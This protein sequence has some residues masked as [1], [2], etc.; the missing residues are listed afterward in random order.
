MSEIRSRKV[1]LD[2]NDLLD[3]TSQHALSK[4]VDFLRSDTSIGTSL[5]VSFSVTELSTLLHNVRSTMEV[6]CGKESS[7]PR[8]ITKFPA[9][10]F[11]DFSEN[12]FVHTLTRI[13]LLEATKRKIS[14]VQL[15]AGEVKAQAKL[16]VSLEQQLAKVCA[17]FFASMIP[18]HL[19]EFVS[20]CL[21]FPGRETGQTKSVPE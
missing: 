9:N 15:F 6:L 13:L 21:M 17:M 11:R 7:R 18:M 19:I 5:P 3:P 12:G 10:S 16:L 8:P 4:I 1:P 14:V 2:Q 20:C